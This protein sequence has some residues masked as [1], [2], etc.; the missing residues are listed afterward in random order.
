MITTFLRFSF[1][2]VFVMG[3]GMLIYAVFGVSES[4]MKIKVMHIGGIIGFIYSSWAIGQFFD[5]RKIANYIKAF[6]AYILG[7]VTCTITL[8][9]IGILVDL[10][11]Y[12]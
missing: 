2:C 12:K 11:L 6:L 1:S 3:I 9:L 8:F 7:M 5:K 10:V 4:V